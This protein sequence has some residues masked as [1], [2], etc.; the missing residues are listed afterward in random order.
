MLV[1]ARLERGLDI[2]DVSR[3]TGIPY[4]SIQRAELGSA[5][6]KIVKPLQEYYGLDWEEMHRLPGAKRSKPKV[7][8]LHPAVSELGGSLSAG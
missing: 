6:N 1:E 5:S 4:A 7:Q 8:K 2:S 3:E